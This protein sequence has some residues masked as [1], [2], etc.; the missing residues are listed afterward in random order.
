MQHNT[1]PA[2]HRWLAFTVVSLFFLFEFVAR[3]E[4]LLDLRQVD[5]T[6]AVSTIPLCLLTSALLAL[7]LR[8]QR[9]PDH[10]SAA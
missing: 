3:I 10:I 4:P 1:K 7:A 5:F 6:L 9:H 8:E 2:L